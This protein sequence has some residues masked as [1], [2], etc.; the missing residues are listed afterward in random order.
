MTLQQTTGLSRA[1]VEAVAR[2]SADPDWLRARRL[3]AW[4]ACE[5]TPFPTVQDEDWRRTDISGIDFDAFAPV[6]A[7]PQAVARF[8]DLPAALRGVLAEESGRA[9]LVVQLDD[10]RY[11]VELDP[12]LAAK[13]V[14]L[15]TLAQG[16]RALPQVVRGHLM[17]RAVRPSASKFAALHGALWSG[18]ALLYVPPGVTIEQPILSVTWLATPQVALFPHALVVLDS[19]ASATFIDQQV[20]P[21]GERFAALSVGVV[22]LF[23]GPGSNLRYVTLSELGRG[24]YAFNHQQTIAERDVQLNLLAVGLGGRLTRQHVETSLVGPGANA[25]MLGLVFAAADQHVDYDTVQEHVAGHTTSDLLYK[26]ALRHN[27]RSVY[28][29]LIRI[30]KD[31]QRSDAY[32]ANRNLLLSDEAR[33]DSIPKLEIEA[34]DVRC[35]HGATIG[36]VDEEQLF[37]L[38]ARGL[39]RVHA[40]ELIVEGFFHEVTDRIPLEG[41]R[42]RI[43]ATIAQRLRE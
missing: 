40:E 14:V 6:A 22:E 41:I 3:E 2:A 15:T 29:G 27:A 12:A 5:Q 9:G 25:E 38:M 18:G 28:S 26:T 19:A 16:V 43:A 10:G 7:P 42:E 39:D 24:V 11:Y 30:H 23:P 33:A 31:A 17:T 1:A 34:N 20:S 4:A 21:P 37:Y 36:P 35:T 8:A 32:Q 13:G